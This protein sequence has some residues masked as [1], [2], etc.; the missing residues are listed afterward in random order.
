MAKDRTPH[1]RLK[2]RPPARERTQGGG[3]ALSDPVGGV[4]LGRRVQGGTRS[5]GS[6]CTAPRR[7]RWSGRGCQDPGAGGKHRRARGSR[8]RTCAE[9]RRGPGHRLGRGAADKPQSP[10]ANSPLKIRMFLHLKTNPEI[11]LFLELNTRHG[12]T[13]SLFSH[14]VQLADAERAAS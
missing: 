7:R 13:G 8:E 1:H 14:A 3:R 6:G 11:L 9:V 5:S 12:S 10:S 2:I 4:G